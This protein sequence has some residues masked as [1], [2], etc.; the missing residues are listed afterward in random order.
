[1]IKEKEVFWALLMK[2]LD[3]AIVLAS[4]LISYFVTSFIR[5]ILGVPFWED[6]EIFLQ[7]FILLGIISVP[8]WIFFMSFNGIYRD[9]RTITLDATIWRVFV[10]GWWT[11][12]S[13]GSVTFIIKVQHA[14]RSYIA[15]FIATGI[16][17]LVIEKAFFLKILHASLKKGFNQLNLLVVGTG[18]RALH[19]VQ[20]VNEHKNWGY[21]IVGL[22]DDDPKILGKE[23]MGYKVIGRIR[24]IPRLIHKSV[25]DWVVFVIP[26]IWLSRINAVIEHCDQEG[27][28]TGISVD[29]F[30]PKIA[31]LQQS[32]FAGIPMICFQ[33]VY[34]KEWQLFIKRFID[35]TGSLFTIAIFSPVFVFAA[36]GLKL[37]SKGPIFFR[38]IRSGRNGR[39]FTLY[40]FRSMFKGAEI[41][42]RELERQNEMNGP[43]FKIRRDPRVTRFGRFMRKFSID[44]LPQFLNVLKGDMSLVGPRPPIPTEV[45]MYETWHRR[46]LSM[47]PGITCLWQ[48]SGRNKIDFDRWMELDLQY[49]DSFSLWLDFKILFRTV[50]VVLTG[51]G[52]A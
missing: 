30:K 1:M 24:D 14:S 8:I 18:P 6:F 29:L 9:F 35:L 2:I 39:K 28:S 19:F 45:E 7:K 32:D 33:T 22:I 34:A 47:K 42:K 3:S 51:Y 13:L 41:R 15:V 4:F 23:I 11:L 44:E 25:I 38:Q 52:A 43:V 37:D 26:R 12:V 50:F 49:I 48:V 20:I 5:K 27:I 46:R 16:L 17:L 10:S 31:K 40:K 21:R 36:I